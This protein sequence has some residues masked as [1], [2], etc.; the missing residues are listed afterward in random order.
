MPFNHWTA[1]LKSS[2]LPA[3]QLIPDLIAEDLR[4]GRLAPRERLPPLRDL[5][6]TLQLNYTTVVRGFSEARERGLIAS[7]PGMGSYVRGSFI[8]LPL[9]AGT[10]AE[11]TMNMPPEIDGHP[12][13][14]KMKDSVAEVVAKAAMHDLMRYQDFGGTPRDRE[15][16]A[17]WLA[18]WVPHAAAERMLVAP[19]IHSVL[20]GLVSMLVKPGQS[21]CVES[22]VYPGLK[23]IAA[24]L[25]IQLH[26]L[27]M[28]ED[29]LIPDEF[30]AACKSTPVAALY[31]CP[32]LH[33]PTTATLPIARREQIADIA[34]RYSM[35]II[36]DDAYGM[37]PA[38]VPPTLADFA[39]ELT[40]YVSGMSKWLGAGVRTAHVLAPSVQA[41]Q[42]VAGA[43]RATTVMASPLINLL[44]SQWLE[45][46]L[47]AEVLDAIRD[48]CRWRSTLLT[49]RLA[50]HGV[51]TQPN[52]FHAWLPLQERDDG[53]STA[54]DVA[55]RLRDLGVA[56]VAGNAFCTDRQPPEGLRICLGGSLT[57]ED[58]SRAITAVIDAC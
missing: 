34:L 46:G 29:G 40:Y 52:G 17:Q 31:L 33:N 9:R 6:V 13:M 57:R 45:D 11:M 56:A 51:R 19:G 50:G 32:N 23:A 1:R 55:A 35:P 49:K 41:C 30:E 3:Y 4:Q 44:V 2:S 26:P 43:M 16:G 47:A 18:Q 25:G 20:L 5:A 36:E 21:L 27:G 15:L 8:G 54:S 53:V 48:E 37:L 38:A 28:D 10:G 39:P 12:A 42:R 22:M 14:Q 7:R 24:Q 58:C